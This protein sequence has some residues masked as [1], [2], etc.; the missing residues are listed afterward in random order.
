M[1]KNK[2]V[3]LKKAIGVSMKKVMADDIEDRAKSMGI[4]TS[5]YIK[6]VLGRWLES[7]EKLTLS[8]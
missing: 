8:E 4:S 1:R 5:K 6:T 7:G 3:D 2:P